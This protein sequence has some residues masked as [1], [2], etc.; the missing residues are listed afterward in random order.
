TLRPRQ[1]KESSMRSLICALASAAVLASALPASA[2]C[3]HPYFPMKEGSSKTY[4]M[5]SGKS[6]VWTVK[7]VEGDKVTV[8]TVAEIGEKSGGAAKDSKD[9]PKEMNIDMVVE[10]TSEGLVWDFSKLTT[11]KN[12]MGD[13][14]MKEVKHSG[15]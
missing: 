10:C 2:A 6:S 14:E 12:K 15:V 7:K 5:S 8:N 9:S 13:M 3:N 11:D 1:P 4:K